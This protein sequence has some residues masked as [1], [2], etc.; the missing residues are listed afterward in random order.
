MTKIDSH[1]LFPNFFVWFSLVVSSLFITAKAGSKK[2]SSETGTTE[3]PKKLVTKI[4]TY[5]AK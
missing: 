2:K 3:K 4:E 1:S 5:A